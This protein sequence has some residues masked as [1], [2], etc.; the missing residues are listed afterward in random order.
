[1]ELVA[2]PVEVEHNKDPGPVMEERSVLEGEL[3]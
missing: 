1:M 2:P 3:R